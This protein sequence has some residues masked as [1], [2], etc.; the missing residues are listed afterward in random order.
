MEPISK[1]GI[2]YKL[3]EENESEETQK[4]IV[5]IF[6]DDEY[7]T[8]ESGLTYDEFSF[9]ARD[10]CEYTIKKKLSFI[11][12]DQ[13]SQQV[14]G[15]IIAEDPF[16]KDTINPDKFVEVSEHYIP[17]N[18]ILESL[19]EHYLNIPKEPGSCYHSFLGGMV[20]DFRRRGI[21]RQMN[22][23]SEEYALKQGF[24]W[25]LVEATSPAT[26]FLCDKDGYTNLGNIPYADFKL[27]NSY[28]FKHIT[29]YDGPYLYIKQ[30][31]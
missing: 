17:F 7:L 16:T 12:I 22:I 28:P 11:A 19:H 30:L 18:A 3:L 5:K 15:F 27:H 14:I 4:L 9:L 29:T 8:R 1:N 21:L 10:Y 20:S 24:K 26:K 2:I 6:V 23:Y 31:Q 25:I 13:Q